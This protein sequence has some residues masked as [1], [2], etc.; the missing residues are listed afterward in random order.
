MAELVQPT[1][2]ERSGGTKAAIF[3]I[4][5]IIS[6]L[7][8]VGGLLPAFDLFEMSVL[9]SL[10]YNAESWMGISEKTM[11]QL[12]DL[13]LMFLRVVFSCPASTQKCAMLWDSHVVPIRY[14]IMYKKLTFNNAI[15]HQDRSSI[16]REVL[17]EQIRQKWPGLASEA[18]EMCRHLNI[19]DITAASVAVPQWKKTVK[20]A[21]QGKVE[22]EL[23]GK[24]RNLKKVSDLAVKSLREKPT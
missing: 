23:R 7:Q 8:W 1:V 21:I 19:P 17:E 18:V 6:D 15:K 11:K 12:E 20:F 16:A 24:L 4:R 3:E 22:E 13:Q 10:L 5:S 2:T 9:S 14:K